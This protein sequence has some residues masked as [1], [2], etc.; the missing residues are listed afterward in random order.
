MILLLF[1]APGSGKGTQSGLLVSRDGFVQISTGDLLRSAVTAGTSLGKDAKGFMDRGDLVPDRVVIGL[2]QELVREKIA[3][4]FNRF[5]FDGFPRTLAQAHSLNE[6]LNNLALQVDH[7]IFIDVDRA[8]LVK[9]LTGRRVC[10]SCSAVYHIENKPSAVVGLCDI[11]GSNLVIRSDDREDV[12][13]SRLE[14]YDATAHALKNYYGSFGKLVEVNGDKCVEEVY[15]SI[16]SSTGIV[17][18]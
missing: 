16:V 12:I 10:S 7:A 15:K 3:H 8:G 9:R 1:G 5:I 6:I 11:C 17:K 13:S 4:G 14:N 18:G 2:V